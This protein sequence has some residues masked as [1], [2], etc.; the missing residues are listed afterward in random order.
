[1]KSHL[2]LILLMMIVLTFA[3][4]GSALAKGFRDDRVVFGGTFTLESGETL[5]GN[6]VVFGGYVSLED[7]SRVYGD[8]VMFGGTLNVGGEITGSVVAFGGLVDLADNALVR[9]DVS[10]LGGHLEQAG[11]AQVVGET[12]TDFTFPFAFRMP[13]GVRMPSI[14]VQFS[15][16]L[17]L[18]WFF[19]RIFLWAALAVLIVLFLPTYTA[20]VSRAVVT[21]PVVA[22]A[23]GLLTAV[24]APL[25]LVIMAVTILLLPAAIVGALL[26]VV[27]WVYGLV[28][29][30]LEVGKRLAQMFQQE[31]VPAVAAGVGTFGLI[32]VLNGADALIPCVGVIFKALAG[33]VG[34][35]AVM[36]TRFG[37]QSYPPVLP[38]PPALTEQASLPSPH[39]DIPQASQP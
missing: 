7:G 19:V 26:V 30:G 15:P 29:L 13:G 10:M 1:M 27:A 36:L 28:A 32:L 4:P 34:L 6:L 25:V 21:Q 31:W 11:N 2:R 20:R 22:G 37:A 3:L 35:G 9:G 24:V 38:T 8:V 23:L 16:L 14:G 39:G 12:I 18:L 17:D 5:D 33:M